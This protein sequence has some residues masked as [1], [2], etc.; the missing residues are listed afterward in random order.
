MSNAALTE[1]VSRVAGLSCWRGAVEP[2]PLVGGIT[3]LNFVVED[4]GERYFV[5]AGNDIPLHGVMRFN[6]LAAAQAAAEVGL[7]P[8]VVHHEPGILVT[9]FVDGRTFEPADLRDPTNL[10][11]SLDLIRRCHHDVMARMRGPVL[12]FWVFHVV[13]DYMATLRQ[14]QSRSLARLEDLQARADRLEAAVGKIDVVFGHNDLL[15]ANFIDSGERLW[16]ID[17]DY[18]GFNSPLFDLAN[19]ASNNEFTEALIGDLLTGYFGKPVDTGLMRA[20]RAMMC[21]S[22]LRET[23]WSM[24]SEI[25]SELEF[26]YVAYS[27]ENLARFERAFEDFQTF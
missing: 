1:T 3:N 19:I 10:E 12:I 11:R 4:R 14:G 23:L 26:D 5:R 6:E 13:R 2:K 25:H 21:A 22:L 18:A 15:A 17:W 7:S 9:D 16:L 8:A 20:F 27:E 24:V